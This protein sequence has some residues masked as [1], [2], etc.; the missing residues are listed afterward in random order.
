MSWTGNYAALLQSLYTL[1][2]REME[3]MFLREHRV[4]LVDYSYT[5]GGG[6]KVRPVF[7]SQHNPQRLFRPD[8]RCD[9]L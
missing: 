9:M 6:A 2:G 4:V 7:V 5:A 1:Y 8:P 3:G